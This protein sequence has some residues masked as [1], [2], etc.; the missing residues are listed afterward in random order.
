M[1]GKFCN[2]QSF[3]DQL[4]DGRSLI[5]L[6]SLKLIS[7]ILIEQRLW[8]L[9]LSVWPIWVPFLRRSPS[10]WFSHCK[11]PITLWSLR[12]RSPI[13]KGLQF[14]ILNSYSIKVMGL[15]IIWMANVSVNQ[16]SRAFSAPILVPKD[17]SDGGALENVTAPIMPR[18]VNFL[19]SLQSCQW[20]SGLGN[21][22]VVEECN[23]EYL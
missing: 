8:N 6:R 15:A 18:W 2:R 22:C 23:K 11:S 14:S 4:S 1:N 16:A 12:K 13:T 17:R 3:S 7:S 19:Q 10:H 20:N 9:R 5:S 21:Y